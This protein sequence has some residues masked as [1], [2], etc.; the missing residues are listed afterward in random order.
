M[1]L[2]LPFYI[3]VLFIATTFCT[4]FLCNVYLK[5]SAD[6]AV[7]K[8]SFYILIFQLLWLTVQGILSLSGVYT[9]HL[10]ALP[11]RLFIFG[12][13]PPI[14]FLMFL[15]SNRNG[16]RLIDSLSLEKITLLNIVR[17]PVEITLYLLYINRAVPQL[18]TFEGGNLD[19]LSG[20]TAII[21][22]YKIFKKTPNY[23]IVLI[24][25]VVCLGLLLNIVV[26][27]ILSAPFPIQQLAF[28][29]PNTAILNFPFIWLPT[30]IVPLV[31]FGH[32]ASI[33]RI[34][35]RKY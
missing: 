3:S 9:T 2:N 35:N 26:R 13:L 34:L 18:M 16:R 24:W 1:I 32:L 21:L 25:N 10:D 14:I 17:I 29:Q 33:R 19:I 11:P 12:L 23:K 30:F 4:V 27:A 28:D 15:F 22:V 7:A 31:F 20:I 5:A 8:K 6:S